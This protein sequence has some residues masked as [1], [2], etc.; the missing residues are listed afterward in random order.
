LNVLQFFFFFFACFANQSHCSGRGASKFSQFLFNIQ[1]LIFVQLHHYSPQR[2]TCSGGSID[3]IM[4]YH[5]SG[6]LAGKTINYGEVNPGT[7]NVRVGS[8]VKQGDLIGVAS[9]CGMLH[10]ELY[11]GRQSQNYAWYPA[12]GRVTG[13]N[14]NGCSRNSLRTK[15]SALLDPR[16]LLA[17]TRPA[18]ARFHAGTVSSIVGE[19]VVEF[20]VTVSFCSSTQSFLNDDADGT[21]ECCTSVLLMFENQTNCFAVASGDG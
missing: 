13:S 8:T 17:A 11:S 18:G 3:A 7:Y 10:M 2:Y 12:G 20:I 6:P 16:P 14:F 9:R 15:P 4:V 5:S 1:T 21:T 19:R